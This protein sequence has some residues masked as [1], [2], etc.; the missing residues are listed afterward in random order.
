MLSG[1]GTLARALLSHGQGGAEPTAVVLKAV[2]LN[3]AICVPKTQNAGARVNALSM[4]SGI[5]SS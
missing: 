2:S 1:V 5:A 3:L 4:L